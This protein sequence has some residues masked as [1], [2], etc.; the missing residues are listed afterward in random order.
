[1]IANEAFATYTEY[2][3][4]KQHERES[5]MMQVP[6][7]SDDGTASCEII[8]LHDPIERLAVHWTAT[9]LGAH[10]V[11]PAPELFA[12]NHTFLNGMRTI[13]VPVT[14]GQASSAGTAYQGA[15]AI[16]P[17]GERRQ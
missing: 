9:R 13:A 14:M 10:P 11:V 3:I 7:A 15:P 4:V 6:L 5:G 12:S 1:M 8:R 17:P 16:Q 2:D